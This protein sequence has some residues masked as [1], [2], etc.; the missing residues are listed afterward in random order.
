MNLL[1]AI[2]NHCFFIIMRKMDFNRRE[3]NRL[4]IMF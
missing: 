4:K 2:Q 1:S 3:E